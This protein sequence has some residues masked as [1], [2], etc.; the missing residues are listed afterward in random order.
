[1]SSPSSCRNCKRSFGIWRWGHEC[2][3]CGKSYCSS[4]FRRIPAFPALLHDP[5]RPLGATSLSPLD[6]LGKGQ[7]CV[8][9]WRSWVDP[10]VKRYHNALGRATG[11][12]V[13]PSTYRGQIPLQAGSST[14][15]LKSGAHKNRDVV[16]RRLRVTAAFHGYDVLYNLEWHR[17]TRSKPSD[18]GK[19]TY[20]YSVWSGSATAGHLDTA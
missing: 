14:R 8:R 2:N 4:C 12:E 10:I 6:W 7:L 1:M 5:T 15:R 3:H 19:G 11:V 17:E 13:F 16:E 9:C 20:K 18:S